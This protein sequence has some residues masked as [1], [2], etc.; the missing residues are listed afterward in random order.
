MTR[1][2]SLI[3][4][5]LVVGCNAAE[6]AEVASDISAV[7]PTVYEG[8][9]KPDEILINPVGAG[10]KAVLVLAGA[11]LVVGGQYLKRKLGKSDKTVSEVK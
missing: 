4:I 2:V 10:V 6:R 3:P 1:F 8:L 9:P 5:M 7:A 11:A